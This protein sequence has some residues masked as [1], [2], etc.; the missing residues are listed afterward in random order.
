VPP[1]TGGYRDA[2]E[3]EARRLADKAAAEVE[4]TRQEVAQQVRTAW[5]GLSVGTER[6]QALAE[7]LSASM[8]RSDATH[9]GHEVGQ[10][11]TLDLLNAEND[12]ASAQLALAQG[13]VGL[14]LDRLRLAAPVG[15][16]VE[17]T[18]RSVNAELA[19]RRP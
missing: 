9:V 8:S 14:L 16:L 13:R 17:G 19:A 3:E 1:F 2:K 7:A 5:L 12:S 10:R 4:R 15:Q 6:V 18:L 11:T